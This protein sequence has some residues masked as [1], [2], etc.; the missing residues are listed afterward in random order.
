MNYTIKDVA[1][2]AGVSITTVSRYVNGRYDAMSGATAQRIAEVIE[3]TGY[4]LNRLAR[5]MKV[6]ESR[7]IGIVVDDISNHAVATYV[8]TVNDAL[9]AREYSLLL[10]N[11]DNDPEREHEYIEEFIG[12]QVEGLIVITSGQNAEYLTALRRSGLPIV[13]L[14]RGIDPDGAVDTV[15]SNGYES[16][17]KCVRYLHERGFSRIGFFSNTLVHSRTRRERFDGFCD[18]MRDV[19]GADG[20]EAYYELAE[21]GEKGAEA[22]IRRFLADAGAQEAPEAQ[23]TDT[24]AGKA[25]RPVMFAVNDSVT[26][27]L[28]N[29]MKAMDLSFD[30]V[31][32]CGFDDFEL[33]DMIGPG[34]TVI[35]QDYRGMGEAA[36]ELL[37]RRVGEARERAAGAAG[38]SAGMAA[39]AGSGALQ[40]PENVVFAN[41]LIGRGS[42]G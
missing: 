37:L 27:A 29:A 24:G 33:A 30:R 34:I 17:V 7:I 2:M 5:G 39:A 10:A 26:I 6:S 18:A 8:K 9:S 42:T 28:L 36:V 22:A 3:R 23:G 16:A 32:L 25:G 38:A 41:R 12:C 31:G 13:L 21:D 14:D 20:R 35:A 15:H 40:P 1:N 4:R 19:C 11:T